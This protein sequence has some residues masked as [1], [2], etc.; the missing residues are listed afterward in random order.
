M[1]G[2]APAYT[3]P[4]TPPSPPLGD[5]ENIGQLTGGL[6]VAQLGNASFIA[7]GI[8]LFYEPKFLAPFIEGRPVPIFAAVSLVER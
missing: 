8:R 5:P 4:P 3:A 1:L 7:S 2:N 6:D